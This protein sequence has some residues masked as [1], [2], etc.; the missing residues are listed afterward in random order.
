MLRF[1]TDGVRAEA[2]TVLTTGYVSALANAA[3]QVLGG[4]VRHLPEGQRQIGEEEQVGPDGEAEH[5]NK[6]GRNDR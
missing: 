1:G 5:G 4:Q 6:E 2:L 3:A